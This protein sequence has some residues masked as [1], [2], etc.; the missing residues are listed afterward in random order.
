MFN[1]GVLRDIEV[2]QDGTGGDEAI[3]QMLNTKPFEAFRLEVRQQL[4]PAGASVNIQSSSSDS[5]QLW[6]KCS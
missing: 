5:S 1:L 2:V 6:P 4:V 3:L